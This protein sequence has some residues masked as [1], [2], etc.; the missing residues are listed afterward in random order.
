ML[1]VALKLYRS[2]EE[3]WNAIEDTINAIL[4]VPILRGRISEPFDLRVGDNTIPHRLS[5]QLG[6]FIPVSK[7][8][9]VDVTFK[10]SDLSNVQVTA[11]AV[12][13]VTFWFFPRS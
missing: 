10:S 2:V 3:R 9:P 12:S 8:A 5:A 13:T 11:S 1:P 7:T 4:S 6:G